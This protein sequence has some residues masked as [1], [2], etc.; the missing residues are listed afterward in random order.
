MTQLRSA[1][2]NIITKEMEFVAEV[3]GIHADLLMKRVA[4][5][6]VVIPAS[7]LHKNLVPIGIGEGL[8]I[9][10]NAN[11][12][13][14]PDKADVS[15]ELEKLKACIEAR[16]DTVMD[17]STG[18]DIDL[19]RR[20]IIL[21]SK[22][23]V[24]TVP[25]YQA[26]CNVDDVIDL[27]ESDFINGIKKHIEDGVDFITIH[28]GLLKRSVPFIRT[29]LMGAV[30]RGGAL[31]LKWMMHHDMENP[32]YERFDDILELAKRYDVTLSLGDGLRPGC[33]KDATDKAQI[34][35]LEVLGELTKK[36]W[37]QD[38]QV[39]IEGP[40]HIPLNE[41]EKNIQLEKDI[42]HGAPFY[43]LGPIV[44]DIAPGYDHITSAIGGCLAAFYGAD[45]LC[46]VTPAE[47]LGLPNVEEVKE[48]VIASRIAAHAA[49]VA[50]K[51]KGAIEWD[52]EMSQARAKL[53]WKKM[54]ELSINPKLATEIR[55]RCTDADED[56]CSMCGK[57][58]SIKTSKRAIT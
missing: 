30:S 1:R 23:P 11:I 54:I 57:F 44:T 36:A 13:S 16:A 8:K 24:G 39:M 53:D 41:I 46:Y 58:C 43:V 47:H 40:G 26:A 56:V 3:E 37:E 19:I 9:K 5:G 28:A 20:K 31:T 21:N 33:L 29:R 27:D 12:G 18:G 7:T 6:K 50:R 45:F 49:D 10:V 14:S 48:G 35:E 15:Y 32:L 22:M 38:V 25:V 51:L 2:D 52:N 17:L 34:S 42:C 55:E 4:E